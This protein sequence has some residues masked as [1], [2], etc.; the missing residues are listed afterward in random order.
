MRATVLQES[1]REH[2]FSDRTPSIHQ[3]SYAE[4][5]GKYLSRRLEI[6][7]AEGYRMLYTRLRERRLEIW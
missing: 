2:A 4:D 6:R 3:W 1:A 5:L 7:G